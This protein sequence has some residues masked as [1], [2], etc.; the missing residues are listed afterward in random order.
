MEE[1]GEGCGFG[2]R[3]VDRVMRFGDK[4]IGVCDCGRW[5]VGV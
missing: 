5:G 1:M 4:C 2:I 3:A